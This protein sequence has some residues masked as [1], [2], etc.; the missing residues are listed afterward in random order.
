MIRFST[1]FDHTATFNKLSVGTSF[2]VA[3]HAIFLAELSGSEKVG[4]ELRH[5][6]E[7]PRM[8]G[9]NTAS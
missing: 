6:T 9:L 2:T 5:R 1:N 7:D 4:L 8:L 3:R